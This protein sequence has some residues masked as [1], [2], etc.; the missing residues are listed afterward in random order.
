MWWCTECPLPLASEVQLTSSC[1]TDQFSHQR[2]PI[3]NVRVR[4]AFELPLWLHG[5]SASS[6][7]CQLNQSPPFDAVLDSCAASARMLCIW[8]DMAEGNVTN[9]TPGLSSRNGTIVN[10][11]NQSELLS[12]VSAG[13]RQC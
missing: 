13:T 12:C 3:A 4:D 1:L 5:S 8:V 11:V 10:R 6:Y 2:G 7:V 9:K